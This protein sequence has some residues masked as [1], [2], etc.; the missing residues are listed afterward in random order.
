[1][2]EGRKPINP[3]LLL[4]GGLGWLGQIFSI[5]SLADDLRSTRSAA[6]V[7]LSD[8][9]S[10]AQGVL[11]RV[12]FGGR[13]LITLEELNAGVFAVT[14]MAAYLLADVANNDRTQRESLFGRLFGIVA[15]TTI[16]GIG[17]LITDSTWISMALALVYILIAVSQI[18]STHADQALQ[19]SKRRS[20]LMFLAYVASAVVV[21]V[22]MSQLGSFIRQPEEAG[23]LWP[24]ATT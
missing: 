4:L 8:Y 10:I 7:A 12:T 21:G 16:V 22:L 14:I 9:E 15:I 1:M 3:L 6:L 23:Y 20:G 19:E 18:W 13:Q 24:I 2:S 5:G 17:S 11:G